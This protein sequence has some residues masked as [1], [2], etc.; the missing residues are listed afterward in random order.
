MFLLHLIATI[1]E[2]KCYLNSHMV[3]L[4]TKLLNYTDLIT[5]GLFFKIL[6]N[7]LDLTEMFNLAV[8]TFSL[9]YQRGLNV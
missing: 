7:S 9:H 8:R 1:F 3:H 4:V 6:I 2:L 5:L